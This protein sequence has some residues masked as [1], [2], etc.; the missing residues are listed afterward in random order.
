MGESGVNADWLRAHEEYVRL[1]RNEQQER[2]SAYRE[3]F[4]IALSDN[5][6][7]EI[8]ECTHKGWALEG[9]R[10]REKIEALGQ[11]RAASKLVGRPRKEKG[12]LP[13]SVN[14]ST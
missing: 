3:L 2:Q 9:E 13:I 7:A 8:R 12:P 10:F 6:L 5:D 1:G 4:S 14:A 11:R